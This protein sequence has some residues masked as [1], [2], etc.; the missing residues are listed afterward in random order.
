MYQ[1][2][3]MS[4]LPWSYP[5]LL[6]ADGGVCEKTQT[7][8]SKI[9]QLGLRFDSGRVAGRRDGTQTFV[10]SI[11]LSANQL[12]TFILKFGAKRRPLLRPTYKESKQ[13]KYNYDTGNGI[14][15][16]RNFINKLFQLDVIA[17]RHSQ[18]CLQHRTAI[19][20]S[21]NPL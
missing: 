4:R 20:S 10:C 12:K 18:Q 5:G 14:L 17:D 8:L 2:E 15:S 1:P 19:T 7:G 16:R 13:Q 11:I 6:F 21:W 9:I 3:Q